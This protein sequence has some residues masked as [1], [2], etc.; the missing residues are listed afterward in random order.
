MARSKI[1]ASNLNKLTGGLASAPASG[2]QNISEDEQHQVSESP[3][4]QVEANEEAHAENNH[5]NQQQ[6]GGV[7]LTTPHVTST[8]TSRFSHGPTHTAPATP[9]I[10]VEHENGNEQNM[11]P[12]TPVM[13]NSNQTS[14]GAN[15]SLTT[16]TTT[17]HPT[18]SSSVSASSIH[19]LHNHHHL[20][21]NL[22]LSASI[23]SDK[24]SNIQLNPVVESAIYGG[25][26]G[27]EI[28]H[29]IP[30]PECLPQ[31]RKHSIA[32]S[33]LATPRLSTS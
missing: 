33:K 17:P 32:Q 20:I 14:P 30:T 23:S 4:Q 21:G 11:P 18:L 28:G 22:S 8:N 7:M 9:N 16:T 10:V 25:V 5:L 6:P 1:K 3:Q 24:L 31:S 19:H 29:G 26:D 12:S 27:D 13:N 2:A 15:V